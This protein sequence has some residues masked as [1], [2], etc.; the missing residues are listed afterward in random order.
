MQT[1]ELPD[2]LE[3]LDTL[4][5]AIDDEEAM[6]LGELDGY[7]VGVLVSPDPIS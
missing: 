2:S 3:R 7:L 5:L 1:E 6:L 4:L